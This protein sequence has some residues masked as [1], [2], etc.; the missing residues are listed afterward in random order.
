M[1]IL[2]FSIQS[3]F[4]FKS[5]TPLVWN[6]KINVYEKQRFF[7]WGILP[8]NVTITLQRKEAAVRTGGPQFKSCSDH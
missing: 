3:R 4:V 2:L 7:P 5:P 8:K 1:G 6:L